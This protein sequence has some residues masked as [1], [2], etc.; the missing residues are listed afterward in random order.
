MGRSN[1]QIT[2]NVDMVFCIDATGSMGNV[3]D[4]VKKNAV[5]FYHDVT[6]VM[7]KKGK[8]IDKLRLRMVV[9][10]DYRADGENAMLET[11]F[12]DLPQEADDFK[13]CIDGITAFGRRR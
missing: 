8:V 6:Q 4:M 11:E 1:Y 13:E 5:N 3:I 9:F 7:N 10:R 2:Y 12:F